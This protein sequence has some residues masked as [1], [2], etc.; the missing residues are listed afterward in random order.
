M[1]SYLQIREAIGFGRWVI[2]AWARTQNDLKIYSCIVHYTL[3]SIATAWKKK[4]QLESKQS[5]S[6]RQPKQMR[7]LLLNSAFPP[8]WYIHRFSWLF[9]RI[10]ALYIL[11]NPSSAFLDI[12]IQKTNLPEFFIAKVSVHELLGKNTK[13]GA[14][15]S[16]FLWIILEGWW[17]VYRLLQRMIAWCRSAR[18]WRWFGVRWRFNYGILFLFV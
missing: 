17:G 11:Q 5:K 15:T 9:L 13:N 10:N 1:V 6:L 18:N 2:I 16:E 14:L 8:K 4:V 3:S 7:F 12:E